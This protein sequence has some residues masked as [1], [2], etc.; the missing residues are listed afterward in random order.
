VAGRPG[1]DHEFDVLRLRHGSRR[2]SPR[3]PV[4]RREYQHGPHVRFK[5]C[6][7]R[8]QVPNRLPGGLVEQCGPAVPRVHRMRCRDVYRCTRQRR[9]FGLHCM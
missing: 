9:S 4:G 2:P 1:H 5:L 7:G 6:G 8:K 3:R